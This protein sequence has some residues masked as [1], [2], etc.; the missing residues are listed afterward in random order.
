[1]QKQQKDRLFRYPM[2]WLTVLSRLFCDL[3]LYIDIS[4]NIEV[5]EIRFSTRGNNIHKEGIV[6]QSVSFLPI[7][8]FKT[9]LRQYKNSPFLHTKCALKKKSPRYDLSHPWTIG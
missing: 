2:V 3:F 9:P 4:I 6:F 7:K 8:E 1:M 5:T